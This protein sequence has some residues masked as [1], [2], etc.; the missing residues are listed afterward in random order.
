[1]SKLRAEIQQNKPFSSLAE[2]TFLNLQRTADQ[3]LHVESGLLEQHGLTPSQ[4]N[5]LRILRGAG[6]KGHPCQEV[7]ARMISRVPDVTRLLDRLEKAGLVAR[8]R[9]TED[10]RVVHATIRPKGLEILAA[11][12]G[13]VQELAP[14]LFHSLTQRELQQ[15]NDLLVRARGS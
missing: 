2:E 13:P 10:R 7:G 12:D 6:E 14:R 8:R 11:L 9:C 15:L 3:L 4:Y 5:V 1:M